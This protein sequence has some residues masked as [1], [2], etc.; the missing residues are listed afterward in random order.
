MNNHETINNDITL[1]LEGSFAVR[2]FIADQLRKHTELID[3][4]T[5]PLLKIYTAR[6]LETVIDYGLEHKNASKDQLA[7][8]LYD[9]IPDVDF[10]EVVAYCSNDILTN[11][12]RNEKYDYWDS[13]EGGTV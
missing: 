12:A 6:L 2:Q 10:A 5:D 3:K 4:P 11:N 8:Y 9:V 13:K 1:E 7:F